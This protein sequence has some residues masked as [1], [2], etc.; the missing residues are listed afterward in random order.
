MVFEK[1]HIRRFAEF[2]DHQLCG[3]VPIK[4]DQNPFLQSQVYFISNLY[5][6]QY[7]DVVY[8]H[9]LK[10]EDVLKFEGLGWIEYQLPKEIIEIYVQSSIEINGS[11]NMNTWTF[12]VN[13]SNDF[14]KPGI[15]YEFSK[16]ITTSLPYIKFTVVNLNDKLYQ[17]QDDNTNRNRTSV[18]KYLNFQLSNMELLKD[19]NTSFWTSDLRHRKTRI[20]WNTNFGRLKFHIP[21]ME[22]CLFQVGLTATWVSSSRT[23]LN[24][25]RTSGQAES[26]PL[27]VFNSVWHDLNFTTLIM[28]FVK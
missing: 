8:E 15:V 5:S 20:Y 10:Y 27:A 7:K 14:S 12:N 24:N 6:E 3:A 2:A 22:A 9:V 25:F 4:I 28:L 26:T 18:L 19:V 13:D 16:H 11:I 1:C 21:D 23:E 17:F